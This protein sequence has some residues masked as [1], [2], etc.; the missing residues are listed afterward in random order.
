MSSPA[1]AHVLGELRALRRR[2]AAV[3]VDAVATMPTLTRLLGAGDPALAYTRLQHH[4]LDD[5]HERVIKA[6]AASLGFSSGADTHL[7]RL[8]DAGQDLSIDQR[9]AR[10]LSD[11]GLEMLAAL[12]TSSWLVEAVPSLSLTVIAEPD[13][14]SLLV[15]GEWPS[16]IEM[17]EPRLTVYEG[18]GEP[19]TVSTG[20]RHGERGDVAVVSA[21]SPLSIQRTHQ[22]TSVAVT[23][24]GETWPKFACHLS[25]IHADVTVETLGN[26]LMVRL[27]GA[28][29]A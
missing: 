9:H 18:S 25:G 16:I 28:D 4:L 14:V 20:W 12:I 7:G 17:N 23:W 21:V 19:R 26:R 11:E 15:T 3:T 2:S 1:T 27:W 6:A 24:R 29:G 5:A 8:E 22:E 10:R 13:Q